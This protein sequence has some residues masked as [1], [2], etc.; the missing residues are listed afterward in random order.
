MSWDV[1]LRE[2]HEAVRRTERMKQCAQEDGEQ[3]LL[4]QEMDMLNEELAAAAEELIVQEEELEATAEMAAVWRHHYEQMFRLAPDGYVVTNL[5]GVIREANEAAAGLLG[6]ESAALTGRPLTA[7]VALPDRA[8]FHASLLCFQ[9]KPDRREWGFVMQPERRPSFSAC[10]SVVAAPDLDGRPDALLCL[11]R[12]V[13]SDK[14]AGEA[15]RP[16]EF[17]PGEQT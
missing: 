14:A 3:A 4:F 17:I 8:A 10:V 1:F 12:A 16:Q 7:F 6:M 2:V 5:Y 13:V 9:E 15:S 11:V